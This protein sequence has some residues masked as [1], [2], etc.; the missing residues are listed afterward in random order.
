MFLFLGIWV[1][2]GQ[3]LAFELSEDWLIDYSSY[4]WVKLDAAAADTKVGLL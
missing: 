2:K 4:D 3:Q 1:F